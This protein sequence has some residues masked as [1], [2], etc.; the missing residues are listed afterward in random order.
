MK[1]L[2]Y[3]DGTASITLNQETCIG[4][5]MCLLVCPHAVFILDGKRAGIVD[6]DGCMECGACAMNCPVEAI[7]VS[8]GVG[9][10][11]LLIKRWIKG[12]GPSSCSCC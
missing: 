8:P 5:G 11:S 1:A 2:R 6:K 9:C 7:A 10:A 12:K 4:C 3:I